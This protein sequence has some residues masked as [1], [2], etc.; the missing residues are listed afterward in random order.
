[1]TVHVDIVG[2]GEGD[3]IMVL[4]GGGVRDPSYLGDVSTWGIDR[5]LA[6]VHYRG[7]PQTGGTASPWWDQFADLEE[8]RESLGLGSIDVLAH[9]AGTQVALA[10]AAAGA[11]VKRLGL[12]APPATWL[13]GIDNDIAS[14]AQSRSAEAAIQQALAAPPLN[15]AAGEAAFREWEQAVAPLGYAAWN[16]TTQEHSRTGTTDFENLRAFFETLPP[17]DLGE[18]IQSLQIPIHVIGGA[19]DLLSGNAPVRALA[20]IFEF[21][22]V[23]M[24]D[25]S[26]HYPWVERPAEFADALARWSTEPA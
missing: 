9:S 7:T 8:V 21:G 13:T 2:A 18:R 15:F 25:G 12:V 23:E 17:A 22:S 19:D 10:Y 20:D 24:I 16:P 3:P 26:G 5:P 4:P 1:M 6:V 14:A 11:P